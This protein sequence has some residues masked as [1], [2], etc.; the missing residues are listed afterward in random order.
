MSCFSVSDCDNYVVMIVGSDGGYYVQQALG[1]INSLLAKRICPRKS[2]Q[3]A[4][5]REKIH[6]EKLIG[7][8][9][10]YYIL[11]FVSYHFSLT[12][13]S[14]FMVRC[15]LYVPYQEFVRLN[16]WELSQA[17]SLFLCSM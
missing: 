12:D 4:D 15:C 9:A 10:D 5:T 16:F 13:H 11:I 8:S 17:N 7:I 1:I 6:I 3:Q 2:P 14:E